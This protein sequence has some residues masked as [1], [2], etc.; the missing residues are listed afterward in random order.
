MGQSLAVLGQLLGGSKLLHLAC[1]LALSA[2]QGFSGGTSDKESIHHILAWRIPRT[3]EPSG[4]QSMGSQRVR[5]SWSNLV[6]MHNGQGAPSHSPSPLGATV[7]AKQSGFVT[8]KDSSLIYPGSVS[9]TLTLILRKS[10]LNI[11][12][13]DWSWSWSPNPLA[14]WCE[15]LTH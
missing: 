5:H 15:E 8:G 4:L 12:W 7:R 9:V 1:A 14:T 6:Y 10:T 2:D 13:K 11:H 3:R